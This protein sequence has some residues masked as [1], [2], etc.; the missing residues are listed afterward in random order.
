MGSETVCPICNLEH[1]PHDREKCPQCDADLT[2]FKVLDTLAETLAETAEPARSPN[3]ASMRKKR[4]FFPLF[5]GGL[6]LLGATLLGLGVYRIRMLESRMIRQQSAFTHAVDT[7]GSRSD[8]ILAKQ[9]QMVSLVTEQLESRRKLSEAQPL[10]EIRIDERPFLDIGKGDISGTEPIAGHFPGGSGIKTPTRSIEAAGNAFDCYRA[11]D[12]DTLWGIAERF[13]GAGHFYPVL[14]EH[15]P[16]L[17]IYNVSRK[18]RIAI[19]KAAGEA[20][21]IYRAI[22][23]LADNRLFWVYTVRSGDT[24]IVIKTRYC[25]GKAC[26]PSKYDSH[27]NARMYP[28]TKVTIQLAGALK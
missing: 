7:V 14:L 3:A 16:E 26:L 24:P 4:V 12:T 15:N 11:T 20:K 8:L 13:Y 9:E 1:I 25:P 19:L 23:L 5:L 10:P 6:A 18:D 2:C 22:T 17:S 21:R 28:G 27:P